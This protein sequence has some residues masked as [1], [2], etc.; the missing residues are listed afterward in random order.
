[1]ILSLEFHP[2]PPGGRRAARER[3]QRAAGWRGSKGRLPCG[4]GAQSRPPTG[5]SWCCAGR[6]G[7]SAQPSCARPRARSRFLLPGPLAVPLTLLSAVPHGTRGG[8]AAVHG[9]HEPVSSL[10]LCH[11]YPTIPCPRARLHPRPCSPTPPRGGGR[12][13]CR[14]TPPRPESPGP[15]GRRTRGR[16]RPTRARPALHPREAQSRSRKCTAARRGPPR[17]ERRGRASALSPPARHH[18]HSHRP[19]CASPHEERERGERE[20]EAAA[21][22]GDAPRPS[23]QERPEEGSHAHDERP[24]GPQDHRSYEEEERDHAP[25]VPRRRAQ[26]HPGRVSPRESHATLL[27]CATTRVD[28]EIVREF[29]ARAWAKVESLPRISAISP[30]LCPAPPQSSFFRHASL[31]TLGEQLPSLAAAAGV[32]CPRAAGC[33]GSL[34]RGKL[35]SLP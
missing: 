15:S 2:G 20:R 7:G 19:R 23:A 32:I 4:E 22:H 14:P 12:A 26:V 5:G 18:S 30:F 24:P 1:M 35:A 8:V 34:R 10:L 3:L 17:G 27:A 16:T 13:P 9:H 21:E 33:Q 25:T 6:H 28:R 31:C 29:F 11:S